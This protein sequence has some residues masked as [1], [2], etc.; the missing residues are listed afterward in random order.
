[1]VAALISY[2]L[3]DNKPS[4]MDIS[5]SGDHLIIEA[6][7]TEIRIYPNKNAGQGTILSAYSIT[8]IL[9]PSLPH[10]LQSPLLLANSPI[11]T[12]Y[13]S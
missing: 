11:Y 4:I 1:M 10:H 3:S 5:P 2:Q 9:L 7:I 13:T 12:A 8:V 6:K